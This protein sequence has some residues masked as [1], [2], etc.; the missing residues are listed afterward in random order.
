[1][2]I[3]LPLA[4]TWLVLHILITL[5]CLLWSHPFQ[6]FLVVTTKRREQENWRKLL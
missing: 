1:M 3:W 5:L 4:L 2:A 6:K